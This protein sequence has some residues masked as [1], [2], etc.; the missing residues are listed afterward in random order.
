MPP[1]MTMS[2]SDPSASGDNERESSF[3]QYELLE[4][5]RG[6]GRPEQ[7]WFTLLTMDPMPLAGQFC[8]SRSDALLAER[9]PLT[10]VQCRW[11]QLVQVLEDVPDDVL[12]SQ[13]RYGSSSVP[14]LV[15]H[16]ENYAAFLVD[17]FGGSDVRVVE[18]GANDGVLLSR[19]PSAWHRIGI[20][21]SDVA[22]ERR[23]GDYELLNSPFTL[24]LAES[25]PDRGKVDLV[26]SSNAMAHFTDLR[27]AIQAAH[28][29]LRPE[30]ELILEV[31]D[32]EAT[33]AGGQWD[34]VYHEHKVEWSQQ[35]LSACLAEAGFEAT[36]THRLPLHGGLLRCGFRSV[37]TPTAI[38]R[39]SELDAAPFRALVDGYQQRFRAPLSN[40]L[41]SAQAEGRRL[42]AYGASGR[43]NVWMNQMSELR[44]EYILD[45]SP[46]RRG[47]WLPHVAVP[48]HPSSKLEEDQPDVCLV[49]AWNY[50]EDI[51]S[52][53]R[54]YRGIW[55]QTFDLE[56]QPT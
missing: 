32:L 35:S 30:G 53:H 31:H 38:D 36:F 19:L 46:L 28:V 9:Y 42:A 27:G 39:R 8:E 48:I 45:D 47:R 11:C 25:S 10:W 6:C 43:A 3:G 13:Y 26:T 17:R 23:S 40:A 34:T 54:A 16:F 22:R 5:C 44:F 7:E 50:A 12:F 49:T 14:G 15:R 33:L 41:A 29:L 4:R 52:K 51:R 20:D 1:V 2:T 24:D 18:I 37:P 55:M 21:P 56:P